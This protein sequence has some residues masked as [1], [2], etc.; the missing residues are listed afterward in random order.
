MII[1][2]IPVLITLTLI[3]VSIG[4]YQVNVRGRRISNRLQ[5]VVETGGT[6]AVADELT[7]APIPLGLR[8]IALLAWLLPGQIY[9]ETLKWEL[10]QA[11][12]RHLDAPKVLTGLRVLCTTVF[13]ITGLLV[14]WQLRMSQMEMLVVTLLSAVFGFY[15][16]MMVL[17]VQQN[18]RKME[19]TLA[20]PD[21]LDLLVICVEAGQG[22]NAALMKVGNECAHKSGALSE[23]LKTIN[24][25]MRAGIT[26]SQALRNFALR[27]GVD[28]VRAFVAVMI[29]SDRFGTSIAQALRVHSDSLRMRRRQR[30]EES[31]RKAPV[32]LVFP[33][34]FCI[35]PELMVVILAPG[36]LALFRALSRM[37]QGN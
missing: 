6:T 34:V 30:A 28:D 24:A 22:L 17:R 31:A 20:L 2:L 1:Y 15:L 21:A 4:V 18:K 32:K 3:T 29:Q 26:R 36:M 9:S 12:H 23:E 14:T 7:S 5:R 33:L 27:S 11:G 16:P 8:P 35:F 13:G 37:A 10:A 19:I 25:E